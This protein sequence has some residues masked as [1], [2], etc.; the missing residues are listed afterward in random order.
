MHICLI[1]LEALSVLLP[2][3]EQY[4]TGGE[5]VQVSLLAKAL[6]RQGYKVS[7]ITLD[8]GQPAML[9]YS[10]ITI[11]K[12]YSA[13]EGIPVLRFYHPRLT[14]LW[15]ALKQADADIYYTSCAGFQVGISALFCQR[16]NRRFVYRIAHDNDCE[17]NKLLIN[18]WR[19]KKIYEYGLRHQHAVLAQSEQQRMAL[20][21]NY[22][23]PSSIATMLVD[24]PE[25]ILNFLERDIDVLWVNNIRQFKRPDLVIE[26]A[27]ILPECNIHIIGGPNEPELYARIER[28]TALL[29]NIVFHGPIPYRDISPYYSR[30]KVFINTSDI[31]GFPNSYLQSWIRGTPL[32]VFFDPDN[33][34]SQNQLG[35]KATS[36]NDMSSTIRRLL[37]DTEQWQQLS[38]RCLSY[39]RSNYSDEIVLKPYIE[40]FES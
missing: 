3:Y 7:L 35:F 28:D 29:P 22:R 1:G 20:A 8:Y 18:T 15:K 38:T 27:K 5:Q 34:V 24:S 26:L 32:L 19:D 37:A 13:T 16:Y 40:A 14:K 4:R 12:A 23:V 6:V 2:G 11:I 39:M 30:A 10:G 17:T 21:K 31:E 36:V 9:D 33:V 25:K